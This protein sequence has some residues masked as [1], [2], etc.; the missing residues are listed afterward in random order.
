MCTGVKI[1]RTVCLITYIF[2]Y[3]LQEIYEVSDRTSLHRDKPLQRIL[4][5]GRDERCFSTS[6]L[7]QMDIGCFR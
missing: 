4:D 1:F 2:K 7:L 3:N 6:G 5:P